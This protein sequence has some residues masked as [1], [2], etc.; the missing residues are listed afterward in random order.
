[1]HAKQIYT[2]MVELSEKHAAVE[3]PAVQHCAHMHCRPYRACGEAGRGAARLPAA[4]AAAG[5]PGAIVQGEEHSR[6]QVCERTLG[7][8]L[9]SG[10]FVRGDATG[11]GGGAP[12]CLLCREGSHGGVGATAA[13]AAAAAGAL[14][15][16]GGRRR[17]R[18]PP[19]RAPPLERVESGRRPNLR[20][21][22]A[23]AQRAPLPSWRAPLHRA[24]AHHR[25]SP[26]WPH[27]V[28]RG[29]AVTDP[30]RT[31]AVPAG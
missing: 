4:A 23:T 29:T 30:L 24:G 31:S 15:H 20:A 25:S 17:I 8:G 27:A 12:R 13:A 7:L 19:R 16:S 21:P 22:E 2:T 9:G 3:M 10:S 11:G 26:L 6:H 5:E 18:S 1:M 28:L 14:G